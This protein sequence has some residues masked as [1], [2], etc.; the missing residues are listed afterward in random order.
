[1]REIVSRDIQTVSEKAL[2]GVDENGN[3]YNVDLEWFFDQWL[4]G[5]GLPQYRMVYE[6]RQAEDGSYIVEGTIHQRV[7]VGNS[8]AFSVVEDK[9][10]RGFVDLSVV[11]K[12]GEFQKR[13]VVQG[14]ETTFRLSVPDKPLEVFLNKDGEILAHEV[15][16][17]QAW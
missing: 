8:R 10:Y 14:P 6:T 15:K 4:R 2:G 9:F 1:M 11:A 13:L 5:S 16:I 7:V 12:K 17:N 3:P